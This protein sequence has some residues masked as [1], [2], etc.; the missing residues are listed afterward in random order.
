M[1]L[2]HASLILYHTPPSSLEHERFACSIVYE[3][4]AREKFNRE[5][6]KRLNSFS[7]FSCTQVLIYPSDAAGTTTLSCPI[8]NNFINAAYTSPASDMCLRLTPDGAWLT[9]VSVRA[10]Q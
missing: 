8:V 2:S 7:S 3:Y 9:R 4:R 1:H 5:C 6:L 10:Q